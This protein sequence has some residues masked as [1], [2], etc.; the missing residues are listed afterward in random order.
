MLVK[1]TR[2]FRTLIDEGESTCIMLLSCW[3]SLGSPMLNQS[4]TIRKAYDGR[5]FH[6][7]GILQDLPIEV[8]GKIINLDV[9]IVDSPLD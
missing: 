1:N 5:G 8:E 9:E 6:P 3:K 7:Y 2:C 4:T